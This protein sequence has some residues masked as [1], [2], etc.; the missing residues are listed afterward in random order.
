[1]IQV[2]K[3]VQETVPHP[4]ESSIAR[5]GRRSLAQAPNVQRKIR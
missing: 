3:I 5:A 1:M 4:L 2:A